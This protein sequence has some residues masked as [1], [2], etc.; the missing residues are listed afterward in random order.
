MPLNSVGKSAASNTYSRFAYAAV[1]VRLISQY[2]LGYGLIN[3]SFASLQE[4]ARVPHEHQGQVHSGWVDLGLA[5][6]LPGLTL[7]LLTMI[8][9]MYFAV[10]SRAPVTLPWAML[11][12]VFIP[13]GLVAEIT[14]KQYFEA[15]IFFLTLGATIV[16]LQQKNSKNS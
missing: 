8:L 15:I 16:A 10:K 14:W 3:S 9:T 12:L 13:F 7:I 11:C 5:F 1:G 4:Y 6:G 2:P